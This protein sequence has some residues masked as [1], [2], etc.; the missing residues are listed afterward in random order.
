[1]G[2][3]HTGAGSKVAHFHL[4]AVWVQTQQ[5]GQKQIQKK[6]QKSKRKTKS[7]QKKSNHQPKKKRFQHSKIKKTTI[8]IQKTKNHLYTPI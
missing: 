1:V 7:E 6:T 3:F 2:R 4:C 5:E 8:P